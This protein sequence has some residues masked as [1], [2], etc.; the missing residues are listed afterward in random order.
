MMPLFLGFDPGGEDKFGVAAV[1]T[2]PGGKTIVERATCVRNAAAA[3]EWACQFSDVAAIGIDTLLA[4]STRGKR[5]CDEELRVLYPEY[6]NS[7]IMQN[8]LYSAMT[9]NG[10][11]VAA[12]LHSRGAKLCETHP[13]LVL[14]AFGRQPA[15]AGL[16][17]AIDGLQDGPQTIKQKDDMQDAVVAAWAAAR[18]HFG[19]WTRDLYQGGADLVQPAWT[20]VYPWPDVLV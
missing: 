15:L 16:K 12:E 18:W 9:L 1:R 8:S 5:R 20:A 14:K 7:I 2:D 19:R 10:A 11:I 6:S 13:K 3:T 4:W 17:A